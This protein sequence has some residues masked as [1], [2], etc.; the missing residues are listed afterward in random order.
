MNDERVIGY[1]VRN[2]VSCRMVN[3]NLVMMVPRKMQVQVVQQAHERGHFGVNKTELIVKEDYWFTGLRELVEKV[4]MNCLSCTLAERKSGKSDGF[5][6]P[7]DKGRL[8]LDTYHIDHVGPIKITNKK[9]Q[10][11]LVQLDAFT[12]IHLR[13]YV[14]SPV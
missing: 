3:D 6:S 12:S 13:T 1:E 2:G 10:H 5:L 4:V 14:I 8:P 9:Y 11:L 7:I